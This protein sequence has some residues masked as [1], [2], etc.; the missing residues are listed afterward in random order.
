MNENID[1]CLSNR[2]GLII[3]NGALKLYAKSKVCFPPEFKVV[4]LEQKSLLEIMT[5]VIFLPDYFLIGCRD[6]LVALFFLKQS[7]PIARWTLPTSV[8]QIV[9]SAYRSAV[10]YASDIAGSIYS[11]DLL[12]DYNSYSLKLSPKGKVPSAL[13]VTRGQSSAASFLVIGRCDGSISLFKLSTVECESL[14][15]EELLLTALFNS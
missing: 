13:A 3:A 12:E 14:E 10:F 4:D 6:G 11:W 7:L 1:T 2:R 5:M 8:M 15:D 9:C